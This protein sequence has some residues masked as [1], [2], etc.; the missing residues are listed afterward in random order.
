MTK[1]TEAQ[2]KKIVAAGYEARNELDER[3]AAKT[4]KAN[5]GMVGKC[6]KY[7]NSFGS[8]SED[9]WLYRKVLAVDGEWLK[10]FSFQTDCHGRVE[11]K[12]KDTDHA[13][14]SQEWREIG[15]SEFVVEYDRMLA[16]VKVP[17]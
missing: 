5:A 6:H 10:V 11:I 17:G 7:R 9:W 13:G 4:A 15:E 2:L 8:G 1:K 14:S 16:R 12:P 3:K